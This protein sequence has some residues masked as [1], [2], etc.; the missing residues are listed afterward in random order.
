MNLNSNISR[1]GKLKLKTKLVLPFF[2]N[3]VQAGFPSPAEDYSDGKL[4]LNQHLVANPSST[5]FVR[6]MGDSMTGVGI[7]S[8]DIVIVDKSLVPK[9]EQ[10]VL[11]VINGEFTIK[12]FIKKQGRVFL[13]PENDNYQLLE[14][15]EDVN[16]QVWG[17]VTFVVHKPE[18]GL[19][20]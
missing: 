8:G 4:D 6:V 12:T 10:V 2:R 9:S 1:L 13:K 15:T 17:V 20:N 7:Y 16:F 11:A 19:K 3:F 14:I 5:F 18:S